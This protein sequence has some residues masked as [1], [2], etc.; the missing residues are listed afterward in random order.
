[1]EI[2][3]HDVVIRHMRFRRGATW[4]GDRNDALGGNPIGNIL[5]DHV[6]S[7]SLKIEYWIVMFTVGSFNSPGSPRPD[8][9]IEINPIMHKVMIAFAPK[10]GGS[11]LSLL[12][13]PFDIQP[14]PVA[15]PR[16]SISA[17]YARGGLFD[18][19]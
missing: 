2:E 5:I 1:M 8:G 15:T 4:V 14:T 12:A 13:I 17:D 16:R 3:T 18:W 7:A 9:K 10:P 19:R 6:S 11:P